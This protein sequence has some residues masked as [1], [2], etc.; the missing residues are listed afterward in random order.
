MPACMKAELKLTVEYQGN[1]LTYDA[2]FKN[3]DKPDEPVNYNVFAMVFQN[4]DRKM[5]TR[6]AE[7]AQGAMPAAPSATAREN[8]VASAKTS[9]SLPEDILK[10]HAA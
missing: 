3:L 2:N 5:L 4:L 10:Q 1:Q 9:P 7:P 6:G 8:A